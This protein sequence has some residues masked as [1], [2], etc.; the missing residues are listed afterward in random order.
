MAQS[1][2][3]FF[4]GSLLA[5]ATL[6]ASCAPG[7]PVHEWTT[8]ESALK[9]MNQN[10]ARVNTLAA[11][12]RIQLESTYDQ[13]MVL[14]GVLY[15]QAP[16]QLRIAGWKLSERI[17][18]LLVANG[19]SW[20][21]AAAVMEGMPD[22]GDGLEQIG[23]DGFAS[24][25]RYASGSVNTERVLSIKE[26]D[27]DQIEITVGAE[28]AGPSDPTNAGEGAVV[29]YRIEKSTLTV[30]EISF[31]VSTELMY[32]VTLGSYRVFDG[33]V[34]PTELSGRGEQGSFDVRMTGVDLNSSLP[35]TAFEPTS[36]M[37]IQSE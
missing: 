3:N 32:R 13:T 1:H 23:A 31:L 18:D 30:Q 6:C 29:V 17:F 5:L 11:D 14:D 27:S 22:A 37:R 28:P 7:L 34:W 4:S 19:K 33:I 25:W 8:P 26:L 36:R 2:V 21:Y 15:S 35:K 12:C 9:I 24:M 10:S 20:F 16:D